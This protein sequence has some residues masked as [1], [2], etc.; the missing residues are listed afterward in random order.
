MVLASTAQAGAIVVTATSPRQGLDDHRTATLDI[1][2]THFDGGDH[3]DK[4]RFRPASATS[5]G[6]E[7]SAL[8]L[9]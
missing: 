6:D 1:G 4:R 7:T 2:L 9:V 5:S 3:V 8:P